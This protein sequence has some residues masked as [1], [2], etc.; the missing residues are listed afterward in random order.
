MSTIVDF[1][2]RE[3]MAGAVL[4]EIAAL[5]PAERMREVGSLTPMMDRAVREL[6][7]LWDQ[8]RE[9]LQSGVS[10]AEAASLAR[11]LTRFA[12]FIISS[13]ELLGGESESLNEYRDAHF[14]RLHRIKVRTTGLLHL[15]ETPAPP[16]DAERL[17]RSIE[18]MEKGDGVDA[19]ELIADRG[20]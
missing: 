15:V 13:L 3:E 14:V 6:E 2:V 18:Q 5:D 17:R 10:P 7:G 19:N 9:P 12:N 11:T 20:G 1:R 16:P 4:K 8:L